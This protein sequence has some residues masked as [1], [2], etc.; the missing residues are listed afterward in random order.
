MLLRLAPL[1]LAAVVF[2][3]CGGGGGGSDGTSTSSLAP[4]CE[5]EVAERAVT[6]FLAAVTA[7]TRT[8]IAAR[9]ATGDDFQG[10][11]VE[12]PDGRSF[13]TGSRG[14]AIDYLAGRHRFGERVRLLRQ[15]VA[16]GADANHDDV[17]FTLTRTAS[18]FPGRGITNRLAR[19][20][21]TIDC[22]HGTIS[23]WHVQQL[24]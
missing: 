7:G 3:G 13:S 1:L 8:R 18:D 20:D 4:G 11:D 17:Q 9:I 24:E 22:I 6:G 15:L 10:L 2:G 12:D 14:R 5:V 23:R 21:G 19:G 16:P